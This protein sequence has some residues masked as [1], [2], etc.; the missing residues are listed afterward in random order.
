[1]KGSNFSMSKIR[2]KNI[3]YFCTNSVQQNESSQHSLDLEVQSH[4]LWEVARHLKCIKN[5]CISSKIK[6]TLSNL[7]SLFPIGTSNSKKE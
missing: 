4:E 1:M 7:Y 5:I 6:N 3:L 2:Y